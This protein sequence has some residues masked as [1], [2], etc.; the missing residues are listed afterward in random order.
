MLKFRLAEAYYDLYRPD[1]KKFLRLWNELERSSTDEMDT[2]IV[3][4]HRARVLIELARFDEA[5]KALENVTEQN[6]GSWKTIGRR[7]VAK[8][9][10]SFIKEVWIH[11]Y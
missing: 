4:L 10:I 9:I 1:W 7:N 6:I 11:N 2:Q 3:D 8:S 5:K